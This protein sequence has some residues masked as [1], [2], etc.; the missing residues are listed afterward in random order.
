M[1]DRMDL[2][3]LDQIAKMQ[4]KTN[5]ASQDLNHLIPSLLS[6]E[7][8]ITLHDYQTQGIRWLIVNYKIGL[9]S[10]L[11]D[12]MGL[13]KTLQLIL[14][15]AW[16]KHS[17]IKG[18]F[19]VTC[20]LATLDNW[21]QEFARF[22]PDIRLL[23]YSG[24]KTERE[25][26]R[27]G[28][29]DFIMKQPQARRANPDLEFDVLLTTPELLLK[30]VEFLVRFK[31]AVVGETPLS[32]FLAFSRSDL[33]QGV[34]E[35]HRLKNADGQLYKIMEEQMTI[36]HRVFLTGTPMQNSLKELFALLHL[37]NPEIFNTFQAFTA[38]FA[39]GDINSPVLSDE[40]HQILHPFMLRRTKAGVLK[41]FYSLSSVVKKSTQQ[42]QFNQCYSP[43]C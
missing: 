32:C 36:K 10:M 24:T 40:L 1:A 19:L 20:P 9:S 42:L 4:K 14:F 39:K 8:G 12:E 27:Q 5:A 2:R 34:D 16:L 11:G 33:D 31:W 29:V 25:D 30:D 26:I 23:I 28:I 3:N 13:G 18:P 21:R 6:K 43:T 38:S 17:E 22:A 41:G 37:L 35:A 15:L 7:S